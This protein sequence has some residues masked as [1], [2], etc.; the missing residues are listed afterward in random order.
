MIEKYIPHLDCE[1]HYWYHKGNRNSY[2]FLLHGAGCDHRMFDHQLPLFDG[3][4]HIIVWDARGHGRSTLKM[5]KPFLFDEMLSDL[6]KLYEVHGI[7]QA[8]LIGQ[9]M[10]GNLAQELAH[11]HP[12]KVEKLVLIDCTRNTG[13]LTWTE[14]MILKFTRLIFGLYPWKTLI[15]LSAD[16]CG[17]AMST[18]EYVRE[19][20]GRMEK[21][22]FV[23]VMMSLMTCLHEDPSF[24]F[25]VPVLLLCGSEDKSGNIRKIVQSWAESEPHC[26]MYFID[27]AGHNANQDRPD[28]VNKYIKKFIEI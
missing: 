12:E 6:L 23:D 4:H 9:S 3:N 20:F 15:R 22:T 10:G 28:L 19:C 18:R 16:A 5:G 13:C 27:G 7:E 11:R 25:S 17:T 21:R 8:I 1:L 14:H 26:D 24:R 2:V